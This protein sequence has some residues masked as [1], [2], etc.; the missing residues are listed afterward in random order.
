M[1]LYHLYSYVHRK[2]HI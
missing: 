2:V 1:I